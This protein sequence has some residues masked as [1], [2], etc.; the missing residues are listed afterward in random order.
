MV[1]CATADRCLHGRTPF[2][3]GAESR[4][5]W[6]QWVWTN[7]AKAIPVHDGVVGAVT[8]TPWE[9]INE[10]GGEAELKEQQAKL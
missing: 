7:E 6:R 3:E 2:G 1:V 10:E 4:Q 8:S 9:M 5:L